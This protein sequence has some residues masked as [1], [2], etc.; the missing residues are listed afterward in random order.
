MGGG[1]ILTVNS[2][3]SIEFAGHGIH[4]VASDCDVGGHKRMVAHQVDGLGYG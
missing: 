2:L 4:Y 3:Y 1:K